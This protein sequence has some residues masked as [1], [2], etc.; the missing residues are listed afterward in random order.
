MEY[1]LARL[2]R[3]E[4][5]MK[6]R[7]KFSTVLVAAILLVA[8]LAGTAFAVS[9]LG[10]FDIFDRAKPIIPLPGAE[11]MV[12][13]NLGTS[14]NE[15]AILTVEEAVFDGQGV[16]V[17]MRLTPK[18]DNYVMY[19]S[20]STSS[21]LVGSQFAPKKIEEGTQE[22]W[23]W[24]VVNEGDDKRLLE[25]GVEL[26]IPTSLEEAHQKHLPVY[27]DE[28]VLYDA[29]QLDIVP[30]EPADGRKLMDYRTGVRVEIEGTPETERLMP[31]ETGTHEGQEDGSVIIRTSCFAEEPL[32]I[33][34]VRIHC[35]AQV[36]PGDN[37]EAVE[38]EA[39]DI[40]LP[41]SSEKKTVQL[42]PVGDG[43]GERFEILSGS[44]A[45]TKI[46]GYF[47]VRYTY[48]QAET[49]EDMGITFHV[50]DAD[51][52]EIATGTGTASA[53]PDEDGLRWW[54]ME[55]QSFDEIPERIWLEASVI[56]SD[57]TLG[58]VEC[59]L[60]EPDANSR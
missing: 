41:R 36:S 57:K 19:D 2:T 42:V 4:Q 38:L 9:M 55:M 48:A 20:F 28:G 22:I 26:E 6:K 56:D 21:P 12:A 58:R 17:Q 14:E 16:L 5:S 15:Y 8:V 53:E 10:I 18:N 39:I 33:D 47:N 40:T 30:T 45:F 31:I 44:I 27:L 46:R 29:D 24:T 34:S 35:S 23:H 51:G 43:K 1:H 54:S 60:V 13:T 3:E 37:D 11:A 59:Q 50:Y 7:Y 49:G 32:D 25:N 52:N